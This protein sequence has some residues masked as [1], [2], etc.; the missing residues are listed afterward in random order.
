[1]TPPAADVIWDVVCP[2]QFEVGGGGGGSGGRQHVPSEFKEIQG[3][4]RRG[5]ALARPLLFCGSGTS[6]IPS[7]TRRA[8]ISSLRLLAVAIAALAAAL[9]GCNPGGGAAED[10][11][12]PPGGATGKPV[13]DSPRG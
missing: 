2:P 3:Y 1:T 9:V 12:R 10:E 11:V 5:S 13:I 4:A 7:M 8:R 6:P